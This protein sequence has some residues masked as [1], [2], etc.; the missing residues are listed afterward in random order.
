LVIS[1]TSGLFLI[2]EIIIFLVGSYETTGT[3]TGIGILLFFIQISYYTFKT[4]NKV[5]QNERESE[6]L[7]RLAYK[8][9]L[10][11]MGNRAAFE[12]HID[13]L[14]GIDSHKS[15]KLAMMDINN[16]KFIN[17]TYGH[18]EGDRAIKSCAKAMEKYLMPHGACFRL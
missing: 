10:T 2:A 5:I 6:I 12:K 18:K 17:D 1:S 13:G 7:K 11:D 15:F 3:L 9:I 8:D 16:L 14:R 4:I